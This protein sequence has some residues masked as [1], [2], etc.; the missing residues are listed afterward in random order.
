MSGI[1]KGVVAALAV[2]GLMASGARALS[3]PPPPVVVEGKDG[4]ESWALTA[5]PNLVK[6]DGDSLQVM[7]HGGGRHA[8]S[9]A[10]F[11]DGIGPCA[12]YRFS[13]A[14]MLFDG[15]TRRREPV[16]ELICGNPDGD[17]RALVRANGQLLLSAGKLTASANGHYVFIEKRHERSEDDY[18]KPVDL[19]ML[20]SIEKWTY[21]GSGGAGPFTVACTQSRPDGAA[22]FRARC[23]ETASGRSFD[24]RFAGAQPD[25]PDDGYKGWRLYNL[26]DPSDV[27]DYRSPYLTL[28]I[29]NAADPFSL[30]QTEARAIA[31]HPGLARRDGPELVLLDNGRDARR[32]ADEGRC[33]YWFSGKSPGLYDARTGAKAPV[34]EIYCQS[35]EFRVRSLAPAYA[36]PLNTPQGY[37][38][39]EDGKTVATLYGSTD[40]IDWQ[41]RNVLLHYP[42][43]CV[44][45]TARGNGHFSASCATPKDEDEDKPSSLTVDFD[46]GADGAWTVRETP[47]Q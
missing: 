17:Q 9:A 34:A 31:S 24:A 4:A 29:S 27:R 21:G 32:I 42:H 12:T 2:S 13:D 11:H 22:D 15:Y 1:F 37:A 3:I 5:W 8:T 46:R 30:A 6:R 20:A 26:S 47:K 35:G 18:G 10:V 19:G 14:Q 36:P 23:T 33:T 40:I 39:S 16:A 38:V 28:S 25:K 45:L 44:E 41:S 7:N 43:R